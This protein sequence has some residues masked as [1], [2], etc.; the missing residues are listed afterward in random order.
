MIN[1]DTDKAY[2]LGLIIGGG[3][4]KNKVLQVSLPY[5]KWGDLKINP[6]RCGGIAEDILVRAK[7]LWKLVYGIDI[8]Y[9]IETDWKIIC[10]T[11]SEKLIKDLEDL[12]LLHDGEFR[13]NSNLEN[14]IPYFKNNE[15]IKS[16]I[17]GIVDTV[18][19]LAKSHRRFTDQFQIVSLEF[20]GQNFQLVKDIVG[21]LIKIGCTPDQ[22]LWNHP[23]Q[24]SGHDRYYKSWKKGFKIRVALDDYLLYGSFIFESKQLS[25]NENQKI[26]KN[27]KTVNG[28]ISKIEG[29][30]SLHIDENSK[31]LP[32]N[33]RGFHFIHY[34]HLLEFLGIEFPQDYIHKDIAFEKYVCPFTLLTKGSYEEIN[35]IIENE[36]YLN[37]TNYHFI[38]CDIE[39][40]LNDFRKNK[41]ALVFGKNK[42]D[43]F[44]INL[45]LQGIAYIIGATKNEQIKGKRILG[46]YLNLIEENKNSL[47]KLKIKI[48]LPHKGTCLLI[49]NNKFS[50]LTGYIN[51][52]FTNN[53]IKKTGEKYFKI[54]EPIFEYCINLY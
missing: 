6:K 38:D 49:T 23:N 24:H 10:D 36:N 30:T 46:S 28:K 41:Q 34:L 7:P 53:L 17:A 32:S 22:I 31:W 27:K 33:I 19:S 26:Q 15:I 50:V 25:A 18:G 45:I 5:K 48:G 9:K 37:K 4:L 40:L 21:L 35:Q 12:K 47:Q 44:M 16:F 3:I 52:N 14:F 43:G 51:D 39:R 2:I 13:E 42:E 11:L 1:I 54:N 8:S 20:K 29:R